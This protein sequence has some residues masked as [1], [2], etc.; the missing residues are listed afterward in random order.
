MC[1]RWTCDKYCRSKGMVLVNQ[2]DKIHFIKD[3]LSK[4]SLDDIV[5]IVEMHPSGHVH[6]VILNLV[7]LFNKENECYS[8]GNL[9]LKGPVSL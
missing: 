4:E 8:L 3:G 1:V 9:M 5:Q 2:E 6:S 7:K